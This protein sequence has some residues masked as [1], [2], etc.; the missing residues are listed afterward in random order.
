MMKVYP[1]AVVGGG[2]AGVMAT[3]RG[4]LNNDETILFPGNPKHR[5]KFRARWVSKVENMPGHLGYK[6]GI[7]DPNNESLE[8]LESG[9]FKEKLHWKKNIGI[10][11]ITKNPDG[12]FEL[13][14]TNGDKYLAEHVILA[15]GVMDVQPMIDGKMRD[16]LPYANLQ[17]IDYCIRCD[18]HHT[19]GKEIAII[20]HT[21]ETV[22]VGAI[23]RE[24]Y[25]NP[26]VSILTHGKKPEFDEQAQK[27][28][29][30]YHFD[31]YEDEI[32][33]VLG[34]P[35]S[36]KLE[37]FS[38]CCGELA[39]QV[40]MAFVSLGM[41]VYNDLAKQLGA[42]LDDRGFVIGDP[43][44]GETNIPNLYVSGDLKANTKK[45]IYTGWDNAVDAAD[46]INRKL[47]AAKRERLMNEAGL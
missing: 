24:R 25:N 1:I 44:T 27:L 16:F 13:T 22:W 35:R 7:E 46:H 8:W 15:T 6:R 4:V 41:I 33:Q 20:G 34:D 11:S 30:L 2:S 37:G 29:K 5:K 31:V 45:Q 42:E 3:M 38:M 36:G 10:D 40:D 9:D 47:R 43:K 14:D 18:G 21:S 23:L 39:V 32:E 19:L 17:S 12:I 28:I 26:N